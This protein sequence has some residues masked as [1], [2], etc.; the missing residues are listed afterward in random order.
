MIDINFYCSQILFS[1]EGTERT[2]GSNEWFHGSSMK[3]SQKIS[4]DAYF[5]V[6]HK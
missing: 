5:Q 6:Q 1:Y 2:I 3:S 4:T